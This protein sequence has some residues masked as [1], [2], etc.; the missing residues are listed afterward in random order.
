MQPELPALSKQDFAELAH[1]EASDIVLSTVHGSHLYGLAHPGS[2]LDLYVVV[3]EQA[4]PTQQITDGADVT[5]IGL[6]GFL[7]QATKGVPQSLEALYSPVANYDAAWEPFLR[8][9]V[10]GGPQVLHTFDRTIAAFRKV[11]V[12]PKRLVHAE[13]IA[14]ERDQLV[15]YCRLFPRLSN[16]ERERIL[17]RAAQ[18]QQ[19]V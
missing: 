19:H 14:I 11:R 10:S 18:Q 15:R 17:S 9:W 4:H 3:H 2:D 7:E 16:A 13:R 6:K 1:V 8:S 5:V 12:T